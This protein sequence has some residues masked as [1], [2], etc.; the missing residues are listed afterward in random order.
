MLES[1]LTSG[2]CSMGANVLLVGPMPTPAIAHLIQSLNADAGIVLSASHNPAS[3]NGIKI[4]SR[5]GFKL[6]DEVEKE[7]EKL[8][9]LLLFFRL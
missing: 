5:K 2:I 3:D 7:I 8:V 4:F 9:K 6:P 1:A